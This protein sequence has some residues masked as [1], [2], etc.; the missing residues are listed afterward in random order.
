MLPTKEELI[1]QQIEVIALILFQAVLSEHMKEMNHQQ[2]IVLADAEQKVN[3]QFKNCPLMPPA[4]HWGL[5][6][7]NVQPNHSHERQ[8]RND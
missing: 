3:R 1:E 2:I 5:Y 4:L 6:S 7:M 8:N